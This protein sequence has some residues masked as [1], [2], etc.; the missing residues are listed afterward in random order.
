MKTVC[1]IMSNDTT[2]VVKIMF[3]ASL[4][5]RSDTITFTPRLFYFFQYPP[6]GQKRGF[7]NCENWKKIRDCELLSITVHTCI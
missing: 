3:L 2:I 1:S 7:E 5:L 4:V 6:V